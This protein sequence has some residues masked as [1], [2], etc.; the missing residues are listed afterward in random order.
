[1]ASQ[2]KALPHVYS[3]LGNPEAEENFKRLMR[4][5]LEGGESKM[6]EEWNRVF[7]KDQVKIP[8]ENPGPFPAL[9]AAKNPP[10]AS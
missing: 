1:V 8:R 3:D 4:A 5:G 10:K 6:R 7:P 9:P 2:L